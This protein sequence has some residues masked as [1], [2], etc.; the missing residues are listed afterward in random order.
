MERKKY[1]LLL[2]LNKKLILFFVLTTL[3]E[4]TKTPDENIES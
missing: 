4:P 1:K 3:D 2:N